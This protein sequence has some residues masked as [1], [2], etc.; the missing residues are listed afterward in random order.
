MAMQIHIATGG[1]APIYRQI[2]EQVCQAIVT[3]ALKEGDQLPSVRA[4]AERLVINPNTIA[5]TYADLVR[6]GVLEARQGKGFF[7]AR[8]RPVYT[9]A[10]RMRRIADALDSF[11]NGALVLGFGPDEIRALVDGRLED[12]AARAGK[13]GGHG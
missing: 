12:L 4:L 11:V 7:V 3:G 8:R 5:R 2:I 13:G 9:K 6:E 1:S 10:E